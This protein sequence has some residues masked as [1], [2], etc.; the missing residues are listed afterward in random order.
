MPPG[1]R[2]QL[3]IGRSRSVNV[4]RAR[5]MFALLLVWLL[6][7]LP[8]SAQARAPWQAQADAFAAEVE[9]LRGAL[10]VPGLAMAVVHDGRLLWSHATG[11]ADR[12]EQPFT[13][14]TPV[15]IASVT[16]ALTTV[17]MLQ[18]VERRE[19]RLADP[20]RRYLADF[21]GAPQVT[22]EHLLT[23]TSEGF[24][25]AEYVYSSTRYALL[26]RVLESATG[27][28][29]E[30]MLRAHILAP[31]GMRWYDSP[32]LGAEAGLVS[33][34]EDLARFAMALD[35]GRLLHADSLRRA[36]RPSRS[37]SGQVLPVG[38][39][40]FSQR[41]QGVD[42]VWSYGQDDP[43]VS[44]A[45]FLRVPRH[46]L[47]LIV[48]GR[49][50][51]LSNPFRLLMGDVRKSPLAMAFLRLW[52]F[53]TPGAPR[54]RPRWTA[55][56]AELA[57]DLASLE[58]RRGYLYSDELVGQA[59]L[60][61]WKGDQ[62]GASEL[63]DV[64]LQRYSTLRSEP[65][66]ALLFLGASLDRKP[67]ADVA[68]AMGPRLLARHANNRWLLLF[69]GS[70]FTERGRA[71][72]GA[73]LYER[74]LALPNQERDML[75]RLFEAWACTALGRHWKA[76]QPA[77]ARAYLERALATRVGGD[78]EA[79]ARELLAGLSQAP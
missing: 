59:L 23:H 61:M 14:A 35:S 48:L 77:R 28:R 54:T 29:F 45:L 50:D 51:A 42:V 34:V 1:A 74:I 73:G 57:T 53:S 18:A 55:A 7:A 65:D 75:Q 13:S 3:G 68:L 44:S 31:A 9:D 5:W 36:M 41:V 12:P 69:L 19:L 79:T 60:R 11:H 38:L 6:R 17:L 16:K 49:T 47:T 43:E 67:I 39:G 26:A 46:K 64:G 76:T 27:Q 40:F 78:T 63:L 20:V 22:L 4:R 21:T 62:P 15:R 32:L 37:T 56:A 10:A 8:G 52:V 66:P 72:E 71:S 58:S 24:V 30:A 33:T 2:T 25:G 70:L